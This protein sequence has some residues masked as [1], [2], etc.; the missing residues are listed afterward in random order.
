MR[1]GFC[2]RVA[3]AA[4]LFLCGS[5]TLAAD[6]PPPLTIGVFGDSLGDGVW[7]GLYT[8]LKKHPEDHLFRYSKV[9]TG[10]TK[11]DYA[12][13]FGE[14]TK[15]LDA[16]HITVAIIMFGANDQ[17]SI[18]DE[19]QKGYLF[20]S[21]GWKR[22]YSGHVDAILGELAKR[23]I[24]AIWLG[25]PILRKDELNKGA[26]YLNQ[27]F[28]DSAKKSGATFLPLADDFKGADGGF[29]SHLPD[30][31]G[32]LKQVRADDGIHFTPWGYQLVAEKVYGTLTQ[33]R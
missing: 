23:N 30:S 3:V 15:E 19:N 9:G 16:D 29:A 31:A 11:P 7:S 22:T 4:W 17:E 2:L 28:Q 10:L 27:I 5:V 18:R 26:D 6:A 14:F 21:E 32:H 8:V 1:T 24:K 33:G 12:T 13:W 20:Q 25:I